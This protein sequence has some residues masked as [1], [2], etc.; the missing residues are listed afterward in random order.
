MP[1]DHFTMLE[2]HSRTTALAVDTWLSA[3][4]G[5]GTRDAGGTAPLR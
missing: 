4:L 5:A 2:E 1:G 3:H